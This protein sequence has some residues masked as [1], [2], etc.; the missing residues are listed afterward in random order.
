[1][2][3]FRWKSFYLWHQSIQNTI[4]SCLKRHFL[5]M[6]NHINQN[7][8]NFWKDERFQLFIKFE[9]LSIFLEFV[10]ILVLVVFF[11]KVFAPINHEHSFKKL[12][13]WFWD[14]RNICHVAKIDTGFDNWGK[15]PTLKNDSRVVNEKSF[16]HTNK[17]I[18]KKLIILDI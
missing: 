4:S 11:N 5:Q 1:M 9:I 13:H 18:N 14:L 15:L 16:A 7:W 3:I 2:L 8:R 6:L 12:I 17:V 10:P